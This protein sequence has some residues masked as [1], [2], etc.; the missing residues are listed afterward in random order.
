MDNYHYHDYYHT[1]EWITISLFACLLK[2]HAFTEGCSPIPENMKTFHHVTYSNV[3]ISISPTT[4]PILKSTKGY[5]AGNWL[6]AVLNWVIQM[7]R[8]NVLLVL[9][10]YTLNSNFITFDG[11]ILRWISEHADRINWCTLNPF[12][13]WDVSLPK[14]CNWR[15]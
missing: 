9:P 13:P 5:I 4:P 3:S 14:I 15:I 6:S 2:P 1:W 8:W 12:I 11:I 10:V 7:E